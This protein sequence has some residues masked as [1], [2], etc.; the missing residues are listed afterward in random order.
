M[1]YSQYQLYNI[2]WHVFIGFIGSCLGSFAAVLI[3]RLQRNIDWVSKP[4]YC[5]YCKQ[6]IHFL[7]NIPLI[8][9]ILLRGRCYHCKHFIGWRIWVIEIIFT[10]SLLGLYSRYGLSPILYERMAL[11]FLLVVISYIDMDSYMIPLGLLLILIGL[12]IISI[13]INHIFPHVYPPINP[14]NNMMRFMVIHPTSSLTINRIWGG[15][16]LAA[17]LSTLNITATLLFRHIKRINSKQWAMGW[18]DPLLAGG[19]GLFIGFSHSLVLLFLSSFLASL[20]GIADR[21]CRSPKKDEEIP[22]GSIPF[23]PF[24]SLATIYIYIF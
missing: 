18:G 8:S 2:I 1:I 15:L 9:F 12:G 16:F 10:L 14:I 4:S 13:V 19:L 20:I 21:L 3:Y 5:E 22:T 23:G 6:N 7:A 17:I 24:L 11:L